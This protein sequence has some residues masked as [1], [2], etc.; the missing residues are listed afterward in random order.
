MNKK[1][2]LVIPVLNMA[3]TLKGT[4]QD[5]TDFFP[6]I[7][8]KELT[9]AEKWEFRKKIENKKFKDG[10]T[11]KNCFSANKSKLTQIVRGLYNTKMVWFGLE[12][13]TIEEVAEA[14][15][16]VIENYKDCEIW[17]LYITKDHE[18]FNDVRPLVERLEDKIDNVFVYTDNLYYSSAEKHKQVNYGFTVSSKL[19]DFIENNIDGSRH[20]KL[21]F[22]FIPYYPYFGAERLGL[23]EV[24]FEG[25]DITEIS[26][27]RKAS[28]FKRRHLPTIDEIE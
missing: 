1:D 7:P 23:D 27:F 16:I 3:Y 24:S 5:I 25:T 9:K 18:K 8:D 20:F 11:F 22:L 15:E 6:E 2:I 19:Y 21:P 13:T 14:V 17:L 10:R 4:S 26:Y 28:N 12:N